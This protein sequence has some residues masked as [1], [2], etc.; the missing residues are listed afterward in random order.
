M[1]VYAAIDVYRLLAG[2]AKEYIPN[3]EVKIYNALDDSLL[4][5]VNAGSHGV[6]LPGQLSSISQET[7][8]Y[9]EYIESSVH[10][11]GGQ[12]VT[13]EF[14]YQDIIVADDPNTT[15]YPTGNEEPQA[16]E[17]SIRDSSMP[18]AAWQ[19]IGTYA[20]TVEAAIPLGTFKDKE[21]EIA[22]VSIAPD[23]TRSHAEISHAP[24][25]TVQV[26]QI[27][28]APTVL[29]AGEATQFSVAIEIRNYPANAAARRV[30]I[31]DNVGMTT[32]LRVRY[33]QAPLAN[34]AVLPRDSGTT[35][36]TIY[37]Q[38][39][40]SATPGTAGPWS[41]ESTVLALTF[42]DNTGAGGSTGDGDPNGNGYYP[43]Y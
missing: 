42:T 7:P 30:R 12:G 41:A 29:Q 40:H 43:T 19:V 26:Q 27:T 33:D 25:T 22:T 20:R 17:V 18:G 5:T 6:V 10:Y 3:A 13:S 38:I 36:Y 1:K 9:Y 16:I 37:I 21:I 32:N 39:S 4:A 28:D 2:G 24:R 31:A 8:I 14:L 11:R 34:S 23:G 35:N 15:F